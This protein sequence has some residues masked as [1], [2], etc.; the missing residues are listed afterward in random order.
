VGVWCKHA[1]L[2]DG[3]NW[4]NALPEVARARAH[5]T[6]VSVINGGIFPVKTHPLLANLEVL[7]AVC[8]FLTDTIARC[9]CGPRGL[10][11]ELQLTS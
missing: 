6:L 1:L 10:N 4:N 3:V 11:R 9:W 5:Y 2:D 7:G 8:R